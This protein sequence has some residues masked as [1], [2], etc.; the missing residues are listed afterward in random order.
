MLIR[1]DLRQI[2]YFLALYKE[3]SITRAAERLNVVQ[4]AVSMQIRRLEGD[5]GV[6]LF[7]RTSN[8]VFPN[9]FGEKLYDSFSKIMTDAETAHQ[10]LMTASGRFFGDVTV[11]IPPSLA[12]GPAHTIVTK[13]RERYP[14]VTLKVVEGYSSNLVEW[15][16]SDELDLAV[17][18]TEYSGTRL[19]EIEL[20]NEPLVLLRSAGERQSETEKDEVAAGQLAKLALVL[21]SQGNLLRTLIEEYFSEHSVELSPSLEI[22]SLGTVIRLVQE[23]GLATILPKLCAMEV[24]ASSSLTVS[25]LTPRL[26]RK[27]VVAHRSKRPLSPAGDAF[28]NVLTETLCGSMAPIPGDQV[29]AG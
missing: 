13:Y 23:G 8:G 21:P 15:L 28:V 19:A 29:S 2:R 26:N 25:T 6:K 11:G 20:I 9:E 5:Y 16:G 18:S 4:P 24:A 1:L 3:Q 7:D 17:L 14:E 12:L 10:F 22:D 27:L